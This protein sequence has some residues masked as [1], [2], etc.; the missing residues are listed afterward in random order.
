MPKRVPVKSVVVVRDGKQ[1][2]PEM[3]KAFDFT[4]EELDDIN[5]LSPNSIRKVITEDADSEKQAKAEA[6]KQA[7]AE[8]DARK[9]VG[10]GDTTPVTTT[11]AVPSA[12][13]KNSAADL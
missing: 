13:G 11:S 4:T 5:R 8:A 6:E 10:R 3:G 7:K 12:K 9:N 1:V 2:R